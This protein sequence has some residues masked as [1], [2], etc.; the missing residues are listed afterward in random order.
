MKLSFAYWKNEYIGKILGEYKKAGFYRDIPLDE[1]L[2]NRRKSI[3][4]DF[5]NTHLYEFILK[6]SEEKG[7]IEK[8]GDFQNIINDITHSKVKQ[9]NQSEYAEIERIL[10][11]QCPEIK[12]NYVNDFALFVIY[13]KKKCFKERK[14]LLKKWDKLLKKELKNKIKQFYSDIFDEKVDIESITIEYNM[15]VKQKNQQ[16]SQKLVIDS[17]ALMKIMLYQFAKKYFTF[18]E[19]YD[20]ENWEENIKSYGIIETKKESGRPENFDTKEIKSILQLFWLFTKHENILQEMSDYK[21]YGLIGELLSIVGYY[22]HNDSKG[23][24]KSK[25]DFYYKRLLK[26]WKVEGT[27]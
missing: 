23:A 26:I 19:K 11:E 21:K 17:P 22:K 4:I 6:L 25:N 2:Q 7:G 18:F 16:P 14:E 5:W 1:T 27:K 9:I 3:S 10:Q 12:G 24:D 15:V 20:E 8:T 13:A